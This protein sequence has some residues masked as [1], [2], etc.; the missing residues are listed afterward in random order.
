MILFLKGPD[1]GLKDWAA[2]QEPKLR[3]LFFH[4]AGHLCLSYHDRGLDDDGMVQ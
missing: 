1:L 2:A 3:I 4:K